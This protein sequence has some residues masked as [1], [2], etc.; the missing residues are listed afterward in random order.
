MVPR[1]W[2]WVTTELLAVVLVLQC[3]H[4][5]ALQELDVVRSRRLDGQGV[6]AVDAEQALRGG[7]RDVHLGVPVDAEVEP[8]GRTRR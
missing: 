3:R 8:P 6:D 5:L 4:Q 1:I 7:H 2:V